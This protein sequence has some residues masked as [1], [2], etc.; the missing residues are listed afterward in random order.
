[1][2][3]PVSQ[4]IITRFFEALQEKINTSRYDSVYSYAKEYGINN[5]H[6]YMSAKNPA[7]DRFQLEWM[8]PLIE[9]DGLNL[10]WVF[11]NKGSKFKKVVKINNQVRRGSGV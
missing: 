8:L 3:T 1:M 9:H 6:I 11:T 5:H 4:D 10:E 7:S 2:N